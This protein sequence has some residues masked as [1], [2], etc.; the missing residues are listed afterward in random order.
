MH[1]QRNIDDYQRSRVW[2]HFSVKNIF[3]LLMFTFLLVQAIWNRP[4]L[5]IDKGTSTTDFSVGMEPKITLICATIH[6]NRLQYIQDLVEVSRA[7]PLVENVII[8]WNG[9]DI[10]EDVSYL[11]SPPKGSQSTVTVVQYDI[12]SLNNRFD[13]Y[14][15]IHTEAVMVVDDDLKIFPET[16]SCAMKSWMSDPSRLYSFGKGRTVTNVDYKRS[17]PG[18]NATNFYLPRLIFHKEFLDIYYSQKYETLR[19]YVDEHDA[20]CDDIAFASV[21]TKHTKKGMVRVNAPARQIRVNDGISDQSDRKA[22]R[23]ECSRKVISML[24]WIIPSADYL[25]C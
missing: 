21:V 2:S 14:L 15:P 8:I 10:P 25:E 23:R 13:P 19:N 6:L 1:P 5:E 22:L 17:A 11:A 12:N 24:D 4:R 18:D 7:H 9:P 20:H 3:F 16:I